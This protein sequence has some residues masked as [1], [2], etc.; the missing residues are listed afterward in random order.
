[1]VDSDG[2]RQ[3]F[4]R[5]HCASG[6]GNG[7][8]VWV[9]WLVVVPFLSL[10]CRYCGSC[11]YKFITMSAVLARSE[12]TFYTFSH[13]FYHFMSCTKRTDSMFSI[14]FVTFQLGLWGRAPS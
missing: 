13:F 12:R 7:S 10:T 2:R 3:S 9:G 11:I 4:G 8:E 6:I 1:M 5:Q 14:V